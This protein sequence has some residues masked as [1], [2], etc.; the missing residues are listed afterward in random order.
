[1][2]TFNLKTDASNKVLHIELA[3]SFSQE[4]GL[5]S[6]AAYQD[7]IASMNTKEFNLDIDCKKLNVTAPE[8]VPLLEG[9]LAMLKKSEFKKVVLTLENNT[10]LKMQLARLGRT[11]GLDNLQIVSN[12]TA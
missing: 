4:D 12:I 11:V 5:H 9:C 3:G 2:G 10:I 8:I 7:A 6:I 1:M